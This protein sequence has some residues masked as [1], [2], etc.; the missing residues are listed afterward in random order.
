MS[1]PS[2]LFPERPNMGSAIEAMHFKLFIPVE[3]P[4]LDRYLT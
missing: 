4:V 2:S 3:Q 1:P